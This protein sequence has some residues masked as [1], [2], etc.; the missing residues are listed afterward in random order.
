MEKKMQKTQKLLDELNETMLARHT[1]YENLFW[2]SYMGDSSVDDEMVAAQVAVDSFRAD[3]ALSE[4]VD[5]ALIDAKDESREALLD[6]QKFFSCYQTPEELM[7][8]RKEVLDLEAAIQKERGSR[9]EGFTNPHTGDFVEA[10]RSKMRMMMSTEKDE[11]L[12]KACFEG[13]ET[14]A[15]GQAGSLV[16]LVRLRNK[17]AKALGYE[18]FY[19]YKLFIGE[20]MQKKE[21]FSL[22]DEIYERTKYAFDD[23]RALESEKPGLNKP[24]N[25]DYMLAGDITK[26]QDPYLRFEEALMRWGRSF[27]ALG[28]DY[29]NALLK[30]DLVERKGKY[31]NGFC[32]WPT[33]VH[34]KDGAR[35][36]GA[37]NFTCNVILGQVG[38]GAR[39][40]T[41]LFH[42]GG[43]AAHLTNV[44]TRQVCMNHE[45]A[46]LSV[47]WAETHSMF[48]DAM[49]T[50]PEWM[51][52][53]ATDADGNP[54][55]LSLYEEEVHS[56][57]VSRPLRLMGIMMVS[58]FERQLYE[59][60]SLTEDRVLEMARRV[61]HKYFEH[62]VDSHYVLQ[63]PHMY[64]WESA[65]YYHGYG[66]AQLAVA[67]WRS[68][69]YEKYGYIVDNAAVGPEMYEV[70]K[71]GARHSFYNS[72]IIATGEPLSAEPYIASVTASADELC[73][74]AQERIAVLDAVPEQSGLVELNARIQ[75][76]HGKEVIADNSLGFEVMA[77]AYKSWLQGLK[78]ADEKA[79]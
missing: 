5:A 51:A 32:H 60:D 50:S 12:R 71:H 41:T 72:M 1:A 22:F 44:E 77:A 65:A 67:H 24:W 30:L 14:L 47:A 4:R 10:S 53:Y 35:F 28:I 70:W 46:P 13:V 7:E 17:F 59:A 69:F 29:Q 79:A 31:D 21:L 54:Y 45:Y 43:H 39:A 34:F 52:R 26:K 11:S 66:L 56:T 75:M 18:D 27:A 37:S 3:R 55:P 49:Q 48:L 42:E 36:P 64:S 68:Y 25:R 74:L 58:D 78:S 38:S 63:I 6:W 20:G 73:N 40:Y 9:T 76:V 57:A 8:L 33:L 16:E 19:A 62:S 15:V 23:L 2:T 61:T